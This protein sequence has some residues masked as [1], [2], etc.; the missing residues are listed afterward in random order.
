MTDQQGIE[1]VQVAAHV[2]RATP[3]LK[4]KRNSKTRFLVIWWYLQALARKC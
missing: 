2:F 4:L 3:G 1:A